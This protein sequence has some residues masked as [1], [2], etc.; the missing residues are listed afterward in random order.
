M[1]NK[2]K[3]TKTTILGQPSWRLES[4]E[5]EA[6][7]TALGGQLAPVTFDRQNRRIMPYSVAPWAEEKADPTLP[8]ILKV[9]RGDFFCM[10]FGGNEKPWRG[11]RQPAHGETANATWK[12]ESL[13]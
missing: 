11:E 8:P 6:Y 13:Q 9:L 7:V 5:V 1:A 2:V 12:F 3:T 4:N 10:P